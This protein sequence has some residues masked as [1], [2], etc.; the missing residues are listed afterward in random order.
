MFAS[1]LLHVVS[2]DHI[3][4]PIVVHGFK[5]N[6]YPVNQSIT[7]YLYLLLLAAANLEVI[8]LVSCLF[9]LILNLFTRLFFAHQSNSGQLLVARAPA[10]QRNQGSSSS[11]NQARHVHTVRLPLLGLCSLCIHRI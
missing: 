1:K 2:V 3:F 5:L 7:L 10:L 11:M 8:F 4:S 9:I 6:K